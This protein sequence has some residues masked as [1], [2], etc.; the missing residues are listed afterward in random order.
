MVEERKQPP[1]NLLSGK[2]FFETWILDSGAANHMTGYNEY[3][4]DIQYMEPMRI[5]L[6]DGRFRV[7]NP[8][9]IVSMGTPD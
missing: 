3:I 6:H 5:K 4:I 9:G 8:K 1:P 2:S 7:A